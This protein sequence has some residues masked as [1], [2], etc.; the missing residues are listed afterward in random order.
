MSSFGRRARR[1]RAAHHK[2]LA[3]WAIILI[4]VASALALSLLV[5]N[6]LKV[7]LDEEAYDRLVNPPAE[8]AAEATAD[9]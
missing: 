3:P 5:G 8:E 7:F 4:C 9:A 6:L 1:H 2:G